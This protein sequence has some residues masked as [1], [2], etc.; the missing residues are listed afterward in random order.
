M[1]LWF[2]LAILAVAACEKTSDLPAMQQE[3]TG[4]V[5]NFA[6]RFDDLEQ[7]GVA[8]SARLKALPADAPGMAE[9]NN[10]L[11]E[12]SNQF[13]GIKD[14]L[15]RAPNEIKAAASAGKP[16][17]LRQISDSVAGAST[18]KNPPA[19]L[20]IELGRAVETLQRRLE[21]GFIEIKSGLDAVDSAIGLAETRPAPAKQAAKTEPPA[22]P[23]P[24]AA[25]AA[26]PASA[27]GSPP[28]R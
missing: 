4:M 11:T 21:D 27:G 3:M 14:V 17:Q 1:K 2:V 7:R 5:K 22:E 25:P 6:V 10:T 18:D 23:A 12:A 20:E 13:R 24:A 8:L 26:E 15:E 16:D 19:D 9:A 28:T